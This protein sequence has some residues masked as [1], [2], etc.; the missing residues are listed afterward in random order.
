M[1]NSP[2]P[3]PDIDTAA[4]QLAELGNPHRLRAF[5]LLVKAGRGGLAV[6]E[7]CRHLGIPK[8]T[9]SHHISHLLWA[10]LIEQERRGRT[11]ICRVRYAD[12]DGLLDFLI[13]D[14][15][16]GIGRHRHPAAAEAV[17]S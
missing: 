9:L 10:G 1:T 7:I 5:R 15:C 6:G 8:S 12:L 3:V 13:D 2:A 17:A 11:L 14:C 16:G 4:R